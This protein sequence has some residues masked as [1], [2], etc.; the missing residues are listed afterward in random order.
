[1]MSGREIFTE[2]ARRTLRNIGMTHLDPAHGA[3]VEAVRWCLAVRGRP[4]HHRLAF[5]EAE[6]PA[7]LAYL[8]A[9]ASSGNSASWRTAEERVR[10][11]AELLR[12][13]FDQSCPR[14]W[15]AAIW[16]VLPEL[17]AIGQTLLDRATE[18][19][20]FASDISPAM[21]P[22][23]DGSGEG[24]KGT[25]GRSGA[26]GTTAKPRPS[27]RLALPTVVVKLTDQEK[28][29]LDL[30]DDETDDSALTLTSDDSNEDDSVVGPRFRGGPK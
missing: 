26:A 7:L 27:F 14:P 29:V 12:D 1:M 9:V 17:A 5:L 30:G 3:A 6:S 21:C 20:D 16:H 13:R 18:R 11:H 25:G 15:L 28:K 24:D 22:A 19:N 4:T 8:E 2:N 10:L 23:E